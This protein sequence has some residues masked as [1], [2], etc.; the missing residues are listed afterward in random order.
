MIPH[1]CYDGESCYKMKWK[2]LK[3]SSI[4][5]A[6]YVVRGIIELYNLTVKRCA[7][8]SRV[9]R[10][11]N[12]CLSCDIE[13]LNMCLMFFTTGSGSGAAVTANNIMNVIA[14]FSNVKVSLVM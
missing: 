1:V 7:P 6:N 14:A 2:D 5:L 9:E 11:L 10:Y 13:S 4:L 12:M 8:K 3:A